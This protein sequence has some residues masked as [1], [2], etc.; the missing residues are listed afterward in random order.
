MLIAAPTA[1][2]RAQAVTVA[3]MMA[4]RRPVAVLMSSAA[5]ARA[6]RVPPTVLEVMNLRAAVA[7]ALMG[8]QVPMLR[9]AVGVNEFVFIAL[10]S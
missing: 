5:R 9:L 4:V 1:M 8:E 6:S 7:A 2:C 3:A 10:L